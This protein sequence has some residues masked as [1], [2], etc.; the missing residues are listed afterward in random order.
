MESAKCAPPSLDHSQQYDPMDDEWSQQSVRSV[1]GE[2][3]VDRGCTLDPFVAPDEALSDLFA[4]G[5]TIASGRSPDNYTCRATL[6][7]GKVNVGLLRTLESSRQLGE[8]IVVVG[9]SKPTPPAAKRMA[10]ADMI[11][12]C[13]YFTLH[14][15]VRNVT[16]HHLVPRHTLVSAEDLPVL[17]RRWREKDANHLPVILSRDPVARYLGLCPGDVVRVQATCG[18]NIGVHTIYRVVRLT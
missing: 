14:E 5:G 16:K 13:T 4:Q 17:L 10:E 3:L 12:W 6:V 7:L 2:M 11:E 8:R 18:T 15:V 1:L 9:Y